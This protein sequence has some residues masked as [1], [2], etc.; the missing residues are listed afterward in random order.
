MYLM[1]VQ[2][3]QNILQLLA[4]VNLKLCMKHVLNDH[5]CA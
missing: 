4:F 2:L 3:K 1:F 5:Y